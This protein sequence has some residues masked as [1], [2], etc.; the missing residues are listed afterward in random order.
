M[1][2]CFICGSR[3]LI[4]KSFSLPEY[5]KNS[6]NYLLR[7]IISCI[8]CGYERNSDVINM[9]D[10]IKLQE[11]FD[12]QPLIIDNR[13]LRW[14]SRPY[15]IAKKI[16]LLMP[17]KGSVLDIGCN[18]GLNLKALGPDWTKYGVE[19]SKPLANIASDFAPAT[20]YDLPVEY[21]EIPDESFDLITAYAVIEHVY[22][23]VDLVRRVYELL[24]PGG[25]AIIMTGDVES[26]L[27]KKMGRRWPLYISPDHISFFS[28]R[29]LRKLLEEFGFRVVSEEWR[30]AYF[31][32]G[33]NIKLRK[34]FF[35]ICEVS[36]FLPKAY[37]DHY[38]IYVR[39]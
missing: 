1:V 3:D 31:A 27:A 17:N 13:Q 9:D 16:N 8:N 35:K 36:E 4:R 21:L 38:Y 24:K 30:N 5:K 11:H 39:K 6:S 29:S 20:I 22:D 32:D 2:K 12:N 10:A 23:P 14:P 28:A 37:F 34:L 18:L 7:N 19:L 25:L 26:T 15:L 33:L